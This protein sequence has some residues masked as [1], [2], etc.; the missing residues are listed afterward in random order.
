MYV[1][2]TT[3]KEVKVGDGVVSAPTKEKYI[4][5][6]FYEG[7]IYA[8]NLKQGWNQGFF[9]AVF[10]MQWMDGVLSAARQLEIAG[11]IHDESNMDENDMVIVR[12]R[13]EG[14]ITADEYTAWVN[15]EWIVSTSFAVY[16]K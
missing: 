6:D 14:K 13:N 1:D 15:G 3:G 4:I 12:L 8:K 5:T 10:N 9:P 16:N 7:L 11:L 2:R